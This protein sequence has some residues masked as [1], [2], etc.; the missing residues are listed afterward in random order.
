MTTPLIKRQVEEQGLRAVRVRLLY[1]PTL[2]CGRL[3]THVAH[4]HPAVS[5]AIP[6]PGV[7]LESGG[8]S[9]EQDHARGSSVALGQVESE[10]PHS[11]VNWIPGAFAL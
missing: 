4:T 10:G 1:M 8:W 9:S 2:L 6:G 3:S 5:S 7:W 11:E